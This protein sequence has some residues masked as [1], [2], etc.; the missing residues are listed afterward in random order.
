MNLDDDKWH[1]GHYDN[2]MLIF[3]N[4]VIMN[5]MR[6]QRYVPV[7][8]CYGRNALGSARHDVSLSVRCER[9]ARWRCQYELDNC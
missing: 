3:G 8:Q 5:A 4:A 2:Y 6:R 9:R 7:R 1:G